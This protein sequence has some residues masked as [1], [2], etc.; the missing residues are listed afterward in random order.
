MVVYQTEASM[1]DGD[2]D[3]YAMSYSRPETGGLVRNSALKKL[4]NT[5]NNNERH[6][7]VA[8]NTE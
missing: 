4:N 8:W 6:P 7:D 3:I 1:G 5:F 2:A